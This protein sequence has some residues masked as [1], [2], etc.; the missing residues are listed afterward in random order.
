M[1]CGTHGGSH[2]HITLNTTRRRE[3]LQV[4]RAGK[5]RGMRYGLQGANLLQRTPVC[6]VT[7]RAWSV[8]ARVPHRAT[9]TGPMHQDISPRNSG[10]VRRLVVRPLGES[11]VQHGHA[12]DLLREQGGDPSLCRGPRHGSIFEAVRLSNVQGGC[13]EDLRYQQLQH[14]VLLKAELLDQS[15]SPKQSSP[16]REQAASIGKLHM[17]MVLVMLDAQG[18]RLGQT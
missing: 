15:R 16:L 11:I 13:L 6:Y 12:Q 3:T 4:E 17:T 10:Y 14:E 18:R 2:L 7:A 9:L 5:W 8:T 1:H